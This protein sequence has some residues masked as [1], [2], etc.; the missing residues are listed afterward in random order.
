MIN[1]INITTL[2]NAVDTG[3][4]YTGSQSLSETVY[5]N[6]R[7]IMVGGYDANNFSATNSTSNVIQTI[8]ITSSGSAIDWGSALHVRNGTGISNSTRGIIGCTRGVTP[9]TNTMDHTTI[10]S[11]GFFI[12]FG[13]LSVIRSSCFKGAS[14]TL[15]RGVFAGGLNPT[16]LNVIDYVQFSSL[17]NA[18]DFGDLS[19]EA[20]GGPINFGGTI[21][22][23]HGGL[24]L[25]GF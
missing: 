22:N 17:G 1:A 24:G 15:T 6:Q 11:S 2:G 23:A 8:T 4:E 9:F 20:D 13:D 5:N 16:R 21:T 25:G 14:C 7:M 10:E 18:I 3:G 19:G 12:N